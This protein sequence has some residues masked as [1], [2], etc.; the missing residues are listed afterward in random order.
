[1]GWACLQRQPKVQKH[2]LL[3]IPLTLCPSRKKRPLL[4]SCCPLTVPFRDLKT[5]QNAAPPPPSWTMLLHRVQCRTKA[6]KQ[7]TTIMSERPVC[8]AFTGC[9]L[10]RSSCTVYPHC[11]FQEALHRWCPHCLVCCPS[12]ILQQ[13]STV[14]HQAQHQGRMA[15]Q[16][17]AWRAASRAGEYCCADQRWGEVSTLISA[18][19][20]LLRLVLD[21]SGS[22]LGHFFLTKHT[23]ITASLSLGGQMQETRS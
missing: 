6:T 23:Y 18:C 7:A 2:D 20:S 14:D 3:L 8:S 19:D 16:T 15:A 22:F 4:A 9:H 12:S 1:M 13:P 17:S 11:R 10:E 5:N 21:V